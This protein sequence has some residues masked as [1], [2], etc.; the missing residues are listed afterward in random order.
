MAFRNPFRIYKTVDETNYLKINVTN[1]LELS[2]KTPQFYDAITQLGYIRNALRAAQQTGLLPQLENGRRYYQMA[3]TWLALNSPISEGVAVSQIAN[4][5]DINEAIA[6]SFS[7]FVNWFRDNYLAGNSFYQQIQAQLGA[8]KV[9]KL[10]KIEADVDALKEEFTETLKQSQDEFAVA[11]DA[12]R[13]AL[14]E[15]LNKRFQ[16]QILQINL[17]TE[18]ALSKIQQAQ[19]LEAWQEYYQKLVE[20]Y[21]RLLNGSKWRQLEAKHRL[22]TLKSQLKGR[23]SNYKNHK[24][25]NNDEKS[26]ARWIYIAQGSASFA[27]FVLFGLARFSWDLLKESTRWLTKKLF[28]IKGQR[29]AWFSILAVVLIAQALII[30]LV[31]SEPSHLGALGARI[32]RLLTHDLVAA[33]ISAFLGFLLVPSLGYASANKNY[34]IYSNLLEQYRHRATVA[35]TLQGILRSIAEGEDNKDI[36]QSLAAVAAAALFELKAV[37]HLTKSDGGLPFSEVLQSLFAARK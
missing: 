23:A 15:D 11:S 35:Q 30:F 21:E 9:E 3:V 25:S 16:D 6:A 26:R 14:S 13:G 22:L 33:K 36:R 7:Q 19:A 10:Q 20:L 34:R 37:G 17:T 27:W 4:Y 1:F 18:E 5:E 32:N 28:S 31:T 29:V 12:Q 2:G 8:D 24:K